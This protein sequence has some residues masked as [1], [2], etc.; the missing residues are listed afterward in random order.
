[1]KINST[2][3]IIEYLKLKDK[4]EYLKRLQESKKANKKGDKRK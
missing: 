4:L 1:M 3:Q 2:E